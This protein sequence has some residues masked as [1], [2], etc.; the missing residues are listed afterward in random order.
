METLGIRDRMLIESSELQLIT[1]LRNVAPSS[2]TYVSVKI[3]WK[4]HTVFSRPFR[5]TFLRS[6]TK[7]REKATWLRRS[8]TYLGIIVAV[9]ETPPEILARNFNPVKISVWNISFRRKSLLL[10]G[11]YRLQLQAHTTEAAQQQLCHYVR[12]YQRLKIC[13]QAI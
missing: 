12:K 10:T 5:S 4:R 11:S 6:S 2:P 9:R 1:M 7:I 3:R 8:S 13:M